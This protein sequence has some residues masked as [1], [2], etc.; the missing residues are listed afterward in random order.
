MCVWPSVLPGPDND[1][2]IT[3]GSNVQV[4][5]LGSGRK[6]VRRF[7]HGAPDVVQ[8]NFHIMNNNV[9]DF[10]YFYE[11][12]S[13]MGLNWFSAP[14]IAASLGYTTHY[15]RII[16]YPKRTGH[17]TIFSD[18]AVVLHIKQIASCWPDTTW[19]ILAS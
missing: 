14:W 11:N 17:G 1:L 7:G 18:Y 12:T 9:A 5:K 8:C 10:E 4:R 13:N 19:P 6:E 15:A 2:T 3:S 16:G